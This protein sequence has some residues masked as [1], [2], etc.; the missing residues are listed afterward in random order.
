MRPFDHLIPTDPDDCQR[1]LARI[2]ATGLLRLHG[3]VPIPAEVATPDNS[4]NS[5][6]DCLELLPETSV[7]GPDG[8]TAPENQRLGGITQ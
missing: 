5:S 4:R 7:T 3:H 6:A 1:E 8:L 2:L